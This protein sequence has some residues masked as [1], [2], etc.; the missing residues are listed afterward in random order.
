M[1]SPYVPLRPIMSTASSTSR[2]IYN[3]VNSLQSNDGRLSRTA[4]RVLQRPVSVQDAYTYALGVAYLNYLLL[5]RQRRLQHVAHPPPP[6]IHRTTSSINDL[7]KDFSLVRDSKSTKLPHGFNAELQKRLSGVVTGKERRPEYNDA[8]VKRTF[9]VFYNAFT[10]QS[11]RRQMDK[12]RRVEGLVL[13]FFSNATKEL[14]EGKD[15]LDDSWKLMV[16][17]H[18]TLFVRLLRSILKDH[19]WDRDRPELATRLATLENKLLKHDQDLAAVSQHAGGAG[20]S[21]IEV[22]VP[23]SYDVKD[24]PLV[25][26]GGDR[27]SVV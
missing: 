4:S 21:T 18:M 12:D 24:M 10:E 11:F 13:I 6:P 16:D 15:P 2:R 9:A 8:A 19:D 23:R 5:P 20:G 25:Q 14:R 26:V 1:P 3:R 7:V 27:K 22:E 17:R